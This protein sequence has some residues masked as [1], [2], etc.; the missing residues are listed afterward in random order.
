MRIDHE[1][2]FRP[3]T[4]ATFGLRHGRVAGPLADA[5]GLACA[6]P[7]GP[8]HLDLPEDVGL[9]PATEQV[10]EPRARRP[11]APVPVEALDRV[12]QALAESRRPLLVCGLDLA[13]SK[14]PE[15]LMD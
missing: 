15:R 2:L 6:E 5:L 14:H 4:K 3:I 9:A 11:L 7:P 13:R 10:P 8:V 12:R 1:A